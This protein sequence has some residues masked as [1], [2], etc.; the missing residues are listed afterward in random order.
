MIQTEV[1]KAG[2]RRLQIAAVAAVATVVA[3]AVLAW[4]LVRNIWHAMPGGIATGSNCGRLLAKAGCGDEVYEPAEVGA[5]ATG[6]VALCLAAVAIAY[7]GSC[8][9]SRRTAV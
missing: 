7:G 4:E 6:G 3:L 8:M 2:V 5:W 9:R 1:P